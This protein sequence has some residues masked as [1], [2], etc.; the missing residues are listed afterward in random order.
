MLDKIVAAKMI[1]VA[2]SKHARPLAAL[3]AELVKGDFAFSRA[4]R[5]TD[6]A[7]IAECKLASP[8]K[9]SLCERHSVPELAA[10]F[11]RGGA[12]ALSVHTSTPFCGRLEDLGFV[13]AVT[14]LPLLRKDFII[15]EYQLYEARWAGAD[16]VLLIASLLSEQQLRRFL[17]IAETLGLDCLVEV[18]SRQELLAVQQ[19]PAAIVG[20]N[21]RDLT[22]FTTDIATTF[23][24]LADID[25]QRLIISE[26]GIRNGDDARRLC[27]AG[28]RGILVG[29]GLV[30]AGD[31]LAHTQELTL[32]TYYKEE[33]TN[34]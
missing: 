27:Q 30:T 26:S 24:L 2:A 18:H 13:R 31:I 23:N 4:L 15:D 32:N 14:A 12:T 25:N 8:A 16:A 7:L 21:N 11:T 34:A 17:A 9:G 20:I 29:E 28:V 33:T 19:T 3:Q 22:T 10:I 5:Q 6:W 1:E